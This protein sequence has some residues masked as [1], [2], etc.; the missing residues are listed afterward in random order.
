MNCVEL[1]RRIDF[2]AHIPAKH[3]DASD[4]LSKTHACVAALVAV[5]GAERKL[6]RRVAQAEEIAEIGEELP[7]GCFRRAAS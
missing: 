3:R 5:H 4:L 1:P 2:G 7:R 6:L